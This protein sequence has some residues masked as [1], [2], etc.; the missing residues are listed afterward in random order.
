MMS[1]FLALRGVALALSCS[2]SSSGCIAV[3][4]GCGQH[5]LGTCR[6]KDFTGGS[7]CDLLGEHVPGL[8]DN[9]QIAQPA[10]AFHVLQCALER[11]GTRLNALQHAIACRPL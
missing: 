9:A 6:I 10:Q 1:R 11:A 3:S 4:T 2:S 5:T 8:V 7:A